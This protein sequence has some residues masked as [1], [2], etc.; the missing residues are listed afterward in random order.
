M[1]LPACA[2]VVSEFR[3]ALAGIKSEIDSC[4]YRGI[5][6]KMIFYSYSVYNNEDFT[7][8]F[9]SIYGFMKSQNISTVNAVIF[10][11]FCH[12]LHGKTT[13]ITETSTKCLLKTKRADEKEKLVADG[14]ARIYLL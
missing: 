10:R 13:M 3:K 12:R 7:R 8:A 11:Q 4:D 9:D 6:T 14:A 1:L 2:L 5:S